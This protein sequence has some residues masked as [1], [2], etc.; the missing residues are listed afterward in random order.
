MT[1]REYISTLSDTELARFF[2]KV[3]PTII[4]GAKEP[5]VALSQWLTQE[6]TMESSKQELYTYADIFQALNS[7]N[8][9]TTMV[10]YNNHVKVGEIVFNKTMLSV[11]SEEMKK[12]AP[13]IPSGAIPGMF[14]AD[15]TGLFYLTVSTSEGM[16][17]IYIDS[18]DFLTFR[19]TQEF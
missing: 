11:D 12:T 17:K 10:V 3:F 8:S 7:M 15:D 5:A 19:Y 1:N 18:A 4:K 6:R 2:N 14:H 13:V 9:F 16:E